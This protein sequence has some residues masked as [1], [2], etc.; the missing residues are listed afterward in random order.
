VRAASRRGLND[1]ALRAARVNGM[2]G[3]IELGSGR[4]FNARDPGRQ[5]ERDDNE[6]DGAGGTQHGRPQMSNPPAITVQL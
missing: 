1:Q 2:K 5:R 3:P 6:A 4:A